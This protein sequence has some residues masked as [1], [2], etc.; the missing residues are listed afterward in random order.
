MRTWFIYDQSKT[1]IDQSFE[2]FEGN[3]NSQMKQNQTYLDLKVSYAWMI[4]RMQIIMKYR[5]KILGVTQTDTMIPLWILRFT[6]WNHEKP[7]A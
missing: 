2:L 5:G 7:L 4:S 1:L 3:P 6:H